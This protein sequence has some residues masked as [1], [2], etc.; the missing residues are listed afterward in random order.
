MDLNIAGYETEQLAFNFQGL[1]A[2]N[3]VDVVQPDLSWSG[4]ITECRRI[5]A[6]AYVH[7][8]P[9]AVHCFSSAVL[10]AASLHFL[11]AIPNAGLLEMDQNPN[12][13]RQKLAGDPP[14]VDR[15]GFVAVSERP[16]LGVELDED[17]V[18]AHLVCMEN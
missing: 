1:I 11:C 18:Q 5:A 17:V 8:K 15:D 12:A 14:A 4:G 10:L 2:G 13:L 7:H 9:V 16:G 6:L 3:C